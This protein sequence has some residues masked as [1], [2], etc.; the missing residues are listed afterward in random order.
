MDPA[1][2][3]SVIESRP[4]DLGGFSVRR[5]LPAIGRKLVGPF[6]FFDHM[7]P[8]IFAPREGMDVRP[9]PHIGLATVTFLFEGAILHRDSLGFEQEIRPGDINWMTAGRGIVHSERTPS[10]LR[11]SG[12]RLEGIQL[13]VA[14]PRESE[15][16]EPS[17]VHH[18]GSTMPLLESQGVRLTLLLGTLFG[19]ESPVA[20]WSDTLYAEIQLEP[21]SRLSI[22]AGRR[23]LAVY[24][25]HG[26]LRV[27]G[28]EIP[29]QTMLVGAP[30]QDLHIEALAEP[31]RVMLIGGEPLGEA[32]EIWWN[33]VASSPELIEA[34]K[35][36]WT[37]GAFPK[38]P[39]DSEDFIPLPEEPP[40]RAAP[41]QGTIM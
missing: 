35:K 28:E 15:G 18:P 4:R 19:L 2:F 33:F 21:G 38:V 1:N 24:T 11:E 27:N 29:Q 39:G 13:W 31:A 41:V 7:G 37:A 23:E 34:A 6:V 14:L 20:T 12:S 10:A 17:F 30:A 5:V 26:A 25:A 36:A 40:Q 9:H 16:V 32:R 3:G 22:P 8:A